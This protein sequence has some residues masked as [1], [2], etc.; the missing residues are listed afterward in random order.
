MFLSCI[1]RGSRLIGFSIHQPFSERCGITQTGN[2][3]QCPTDQVKADLPTESVR[4]N[5]TTAYRCDEPYGWCY[6]QTEISD[7]NHYEL[8]ERKQR[9]IVILQHRPGP[10]AKCNLMC[11]ARVRNVTSRAA[12]EREQHQV[13]IVNTLPGHRSDV[14]GMA[15]LLII[16]VNLP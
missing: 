12:E 8:M 6:K 4:P 14:C 7:D 16:Q 3:Y 1:S 13:T 10:V 9:G 2:K 5:N 15:E 11:A